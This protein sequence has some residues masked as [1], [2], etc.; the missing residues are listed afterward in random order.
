MVKR[1]TVSLEEPLLDRFDEFIASHSYSNRSEAIRDLI[2]E[3]LMR[4]DWEE[5]RDVIGV[6]SLVYDHSQLQLQSRI[7]RLQHE[8]HDQIISTTHVHVDHD[9]CLEVI[10][11]G[12]KAG[13]IRVLVDSLSA[14]RG[15]RN[16]SLSTTGADTTT[17]SNENIHT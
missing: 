15:V 8:C 9:N 17:N 4:R 6:I 14:I 16:C 7:T 5:N 11:V 13:N 10:I 12:G 3:S 1:F 2:R